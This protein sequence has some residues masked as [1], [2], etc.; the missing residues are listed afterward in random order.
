MFVAIN[1]PRQSWA[2]EYRTLSPGCTLRSLRLLDS[3]KALAAWRS[4]VRLWSIINEKGKQRQTMGPTRRSRV[5]S[6]RTLS[7]LT[8]GQLAELR[9]LVLF[10]H[11]EH[12]N[13]CYSLYIAARQVPYVL[14]LA[15]GK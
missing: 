8:L 6:T 12:G 2:G 11:G 10:L 1:I 5:K 13:V 9:K 15:G 7:S 4:L 3:R 14:N